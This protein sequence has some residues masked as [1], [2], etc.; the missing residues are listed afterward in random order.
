MEECTDVIEHPTECPK[1]DENAND[2]VN[3]C[4]SPGVDDVDCP[5]GKKVFKYNHGLS[6]MH[7]Y[8]INL[9]KTG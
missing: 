6:L 7:S 9:M 3:D 4:W 1:P 5:T 2:C 8:Y